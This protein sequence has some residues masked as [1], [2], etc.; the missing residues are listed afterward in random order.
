MAFR[1]NISADSEFRTELLKLVRENIKPAIEEIVSKLMPD[2]IAKMIEKYLEQIPIGRYNNHPD[3]GKTRLQLLFAKV[4][5]AVS[6]KAGTIANDL[7]KKI[8]KDFETNINSRVEYL[9][10]QRLDSKQ[11]ELIRDV[12]R[13]E[14]SRAF[15]P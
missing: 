1:L 4:E 5:E 7:S 9:F 12:I 13:E 11:K 3:A 2:T 14:L 10:A 15:K 8:I 6:Q